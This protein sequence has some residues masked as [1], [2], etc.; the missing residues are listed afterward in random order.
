MRYLFVITVGVL[1]LLGVQG[2]SLHGETLASPFINMA[3]EHKLGQDE[4]WLRILFYQ[5]HSF[6]REPHGLIDDPD[7]YL[8]SDGK[9]DAESELFATIRDF[10]AP[11]D[12]AHLDEHALC[13]YP[14]RRKYLV[15]RLDKLEEA[16]PQV[17]CPRFDQ[18][19]KD[20]TYQSISL[21]FSSFFPDNPA[22]M[23]GHIFLRLHRTGG[24]STSDLL[25]DSINF[26]AFTDTS[27]PL[28]YNLKGAFGGF[29]GRFSLMPYYMKIQEYNNLESR[30]LWEY[31]LLANQEQIQK[32][33]LSLWEFGPHHANY[34]YF[35]DNCSYVMLMLMETAEISWDFTSKLPIWATPSACL[36]A[37]NDQP[38]LILQTK[39]RASAL[40]RYQERYDQ[41]DQQ[42]RKQLE[43]IVAAGK[44]PG[45][46]GR[47]SRLL[48]SV[49]EYIDF[50]E[51]LAGTLAP[52]RY[53][54]LRE[55]TLLKRSQIKEPPRQ[56]TFSPGGRD[57]RLAA[58]ESWLMLSGARQNSDSL[59]RLQWQPVLHDL[60][61]ERQGYADDMQLQ[62]MPMSLA[63]F[64]EDN[65]LDL[66]AFDIINVISIQPHQKLI[67]PRSW[68]LSI[69]YQRQSLCPTIMNDYSVCPSTLV[70]YGRGASA[71]LGTGAYAPVLAGFISLDLGAR[72][73]DNEHIGL[74]GLGPEVLLSGKLPLDIGYTG[75]ASLIRYRLSDL[76]FETKLQAEAQ[77]ALRV[78]MRH[79]IRLSSAWERLERDGTLGLRRSAQLGV[80]HYF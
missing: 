54:A 74:A 20:R 33:L 15:S 66:E 49:L 47:S 39:F 56:L 76:T 62:I 80:L 42:E 73:Q 27:N 31:P 43:E 53:A 78:G 1:S 29:D 28:L 45:I 8:D 57:P 75:H 64:P 55:E 10:L 22:S 51:K 71:G 18:W 32:L 59:M 67:A 2:H 68:V 6:V 3:R 72:D 17:A 11:Q 40:S 12:P 4:G 61:G 21:V 60:L 9:F 16:L 41:L 69:G 58:P 79:Q 19:W 5:R 37:V 13:R 34:Y 7:F 24:R 38:N 65:R 44:D 14:A 63:F 50:Q 52:V 23:F 26:A 35:D 46:E 25:D 48:D 30:D 36:K 77:L 70:H